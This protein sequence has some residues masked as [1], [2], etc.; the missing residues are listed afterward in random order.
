[1]LD[2][3][4]GDAEPGVERILPDLDPVAFPVWL[5]AHRDV[6]RARRLRAVWDALAEGLR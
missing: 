2:A 6:R 1:V 4:I 3:R 5:V